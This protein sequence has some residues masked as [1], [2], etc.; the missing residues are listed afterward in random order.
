[1]PLPCPLPLQRVAYRLGSSA[2]P[3]RERQ[4]ALRLRAQNRKPDRAD[5]PAPALR[6]LLALPATARAPLDLAFGAGKTRL[7]VPLYQPGSKLAGSVD[8][9]VF[10]AGA[11]ALEAVVLTKTACG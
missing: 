2:L 7:V 11:L 4:R 9:H 10:A 6:G 5:T 3:A 1:M 8:V